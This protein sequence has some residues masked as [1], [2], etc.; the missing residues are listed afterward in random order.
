MLITKIRQRPYHDPYFTRHA[1]DV[2]WAQDKQGVK[3]QSGP[4][5]VKGPLDIDVCKLAFSEIAP[6]HGFGR[7]GLMSAQIKLHSLISQ[8]VLEPS[9]VNVSKRLP[10]RASKSG[11][12]P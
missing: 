8:D 3:V 11:C 1:I 12:C 5:I 9:H 10:S 7:I 2:Q 4:L 6:D